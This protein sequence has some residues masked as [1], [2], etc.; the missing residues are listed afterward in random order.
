MQNI[1][2]KN[3]F[4]ILGIFI[5]AL[6]F[7]IA[8]AQ[9]TMASNFLD[10]DKDGLTDFEENMIYH[11]NPKLAD[12]DEDG[13]PDSIEIANGFSPLD[14][15]GKTMLQVDSDQD[16]LVDGWEIILGTNLLNPNTD[17]DNQM[18]GAEVDAGLDP[19]SAS[20]KKIEKKID[21]NL[22]DQSLNYYFG[23]E[24]LETIKISSGLPGLDTVTGDFEVL[25][26]VPVRTYGARGHSIYLP[27]TKWN[28]HFYTGIMPFFIHGAYWHNNFGKKASHGC[29][30]VAYSNMERLYNFAEVGTK[31]KIHETK[32]KLK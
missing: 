4:S 14:P 9:S 6:L 30:N 26:K 1:Q 29:V 23:N 22:D 7:S 10:T 28:L 32:R 31:I 5:S 13:Y 17:G 19:L 24:K 18:D 3:K 15:S 21:V 16:G 2:T 27:D 12:T 20:M 25:D 8:N 11:T